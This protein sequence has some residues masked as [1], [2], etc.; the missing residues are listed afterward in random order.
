MS[1]IILLYSS[2]CS[3]TDRRSRIYNQSVSEP[4]INFLLMLVILPRNSRLRMRTYQF[5][6]DIPVEHGSGMRSSRGTVQREQVTDL[7]LILLATNSW[8]FLWQFWKSAEW[9]IN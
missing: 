8:T 6:I 4:L 5:V 7:V 3:F 1:R 9:N 2:S